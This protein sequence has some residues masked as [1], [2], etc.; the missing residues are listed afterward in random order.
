MNSGLP[1]HADAFADTLAIGTDTSPDPKIEIAVRQFQ[2]LLGV[3]SC[4]VAYVEPK[5]RAHR[6]LHAVGY[7]AEVLPT[8]D[9]FLASP[10]YRRVEPPVPS[11]RLWRDNPDF[12]ATPTVVNVLKPAGFRDGTSLQLRDREGYEVGSLH[13][14]LFTE[15]LSETQRRCLTDLSEFI[16]QALAARRRRDQFGLSQREGAVLRLIV[17]G[18]SNPEIAEELYIA[19]RTVATH[20]ESLLTKLGVANRVAA[21]V[22]AV[23]HDL[24]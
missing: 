23:R 14:N 12:V 7:S 9:A 2:R 17:D 20:V 6:V 8:I 10:L 4:A 24:V 21:A 1:A 13:L 5:S 18:A 15:G 3:P 16:G 19:R 11:I 22:V